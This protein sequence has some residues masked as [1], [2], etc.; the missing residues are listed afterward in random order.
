MQSL[1][2][3]GLHVGLIMDGS[4]RWA[5]QRGWPR[6][7]GHRAGAR[8]VRHLVEAAPALGVGT[9][10]LFAFSSDNWQRPPDEIKGLMEIFGNFFRAEAASYA[11]GGIRMNV[12]GRR[13][14]LPP[15]LRADMVSA[16]KATRAGRR[17]LLRLAI[18]YSARETLV[19]T[20]LQFKGSNSPSPDSFALRLAQVMHAEPAAPEV[21]MIIRTGGEQR[22]SDF[23]LWESAYAE[24]FFTLVLWPDFNSG[25]LKSLIEEFHSRHRRFGR[26]P[27]AAAV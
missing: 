14:R 7:A 21:D 25:D 24:L 2:P 18:D 19:R 23:L 13:D 5:A 20:A 6:T 27:E 3:S 26:I 10:T 22:L 4:G 8:T 11:R 12:I 17:L 9:L 15:A 1:I 16:E